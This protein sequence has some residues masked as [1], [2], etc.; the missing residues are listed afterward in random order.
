M[1]EVLL[2]VHCAALSADHHNLRPD[3]LRA[4]LLPELR[5][6]QM[7]ERDWLVHRILVDG[8]HSDNGLLSAGQSK[9]L[10]HRGRCSKPALVNWRAWKRSH[11]DS[12]DSRSRSDL[13]TA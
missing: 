3:Q 13:G 9:R 1:V 4:D 7:G 11:L 8:M 12:L 2:G 10:I 5:V 6:S